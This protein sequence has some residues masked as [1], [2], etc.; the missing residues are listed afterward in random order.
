MV[1]MISDNERRACKRKVRYATDA[2]A[3]MAIK[4]INPTRA[5]KKPSRVYKCPV[6][7]GYHLTSHRQ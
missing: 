6:C 2:A 7:S 4:K 1:I 5:L 3:Q